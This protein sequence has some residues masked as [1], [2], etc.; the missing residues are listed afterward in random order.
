MKYDVLILN[1]HFK[2]VLKMHSLE[3][4]LR[5]IQIILG[6]HNLTYAFNKYPGIPVYMKFSQFS[7]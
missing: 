5:A 4:L 3:V 6:F 1:M 2:N 7:T